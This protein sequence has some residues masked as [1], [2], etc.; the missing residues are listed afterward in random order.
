MSEFMR[1]LLFTALTVSVSDPAG[2]II[3]LRL[4]RVVC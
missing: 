2:V 3:I 4:C 1:M